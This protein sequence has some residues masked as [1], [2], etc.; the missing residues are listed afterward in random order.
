MVVYFAM[1]L[2]N[3]PPATWLF[4]FLKRSQFSGNLDNS[5]GKSNAQIFPY[6]SYL[7][8]VYVIPSS[9]TSAHKKHI[10]LNNI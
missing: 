3:K 2:Q 7:G 5:S 1:K 8:L 9:Y 6:C 10:Q 4:E